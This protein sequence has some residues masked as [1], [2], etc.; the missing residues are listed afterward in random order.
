M[1]R[2]NSILT[3]IASSLLILSINL[4]SMENDPI[5]EKQGPPLLMQI[6]QRQVSEQSTSE[7]NPAALPPET[8]P[9]FQRST[10]V[11]SPQPFNPVVKNI[12]GVLSRFVVSTT[13][14]DQD[15]TTAAN[16][17]DNPADASA[18]K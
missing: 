7:N 2:I 12:A 5:K 10:F 14:D 16:Q 15:T 8:I 4:V 11:V 1:K 9:A 3:V 18:D 17:D 13:V 6:M